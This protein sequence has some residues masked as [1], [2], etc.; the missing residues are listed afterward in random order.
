MEDVAAL[1]GTM[2]T[3]RLL[4][5]T[6]PWPCAAVQPCG[7]SR[8]AWGGDLP[9]A[10][11]TCVLCDVFFGPVPGSLLPTVMHWLQDHGMMGI[12]YSQHAHVSCCRLMA[13]SAS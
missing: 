11:I 8:R 3:P 12:E 1:A 13:S 6:Q 2:V 4:S 9:W 10:H 5:C 7:A